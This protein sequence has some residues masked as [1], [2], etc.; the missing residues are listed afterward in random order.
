MSVPI[1]ITFVLAFMLSS[2]LQLDDDVV[3]EL[4]NNI[5]EEPEWFYLKKKDGLAEDTVTTMLKDSR[6]DYWFGHFKKGITKWDGDKGFI[7]I[8]AEKCH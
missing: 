3:T 6:G 8:F 7:R 2:C 4:Q 1:R 5:E